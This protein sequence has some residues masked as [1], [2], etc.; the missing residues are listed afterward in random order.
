MVCNGVL[1]GIVSGGKGCARPL[2]PGI[3]TDIFYY[4][5]W[6]SENDIIMVTK[7]NNCTNN[8][9]K[10]FTNNHSTHKMPTIIVV[11]I[12]F[13][14]ILLSVM[15]YSWNQVFIDK[16]IIISDDTGKRKLELTHFNKYRNILL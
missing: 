16:L 6:I 14:F 11:M 8:L 3:Y 9:I 1:T 4:M 5:D 12:S 13:S 2:F 10:R 7:L 15:L